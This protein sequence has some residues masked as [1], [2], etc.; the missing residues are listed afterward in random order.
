MTNAN[1]SK[2]E[3]VG[4][5]GN[6]SRSSRRVLSTEASITQ[7]EQQ[8]Q[9]ALLWERD[10]SSAGVNNCASVDVDNSALDATITDLSSSLQPPTIIQVDEKYVKTYIPSSLIINFPYLSAKQRSK[11][12]QG[13]A[14]SPVV[15]ILIFFYQRLLFFSRVALATNG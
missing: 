1:S 8:N 11:S 2:I 3:P 5:I 10:N 13:N 15:I 4:R 14:V 12:N 6:R 9:S 7:L